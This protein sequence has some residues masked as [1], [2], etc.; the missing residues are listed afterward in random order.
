[1]LTLWLSSSAS[2]GGDE[3]DVIP[4]GEVVSGLPILILLLLR[5]G[6]RFL[7]RPDADSMRTAEQIRGPS[8]GHAATSGVCDAA[9]ELRGCCR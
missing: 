7:P 4:L 1:M 9:P 2:L 3:Q 8:P 6:A 5:V